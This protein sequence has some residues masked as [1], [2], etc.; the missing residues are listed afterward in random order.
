M[1]PPIRAATVGLGEATSSALRRA[2]EQDIEVFQPLLSELRLHP[3]GTPILNFP[4]AGSIEKD[5]WLTLTRILD[6]RRSYSITAKKYM[7]LGPETCR[8]GD[9][10]WVLMGSSVPFILRPMALKGVE[11]ETVQVH[12]L[13]GYCFVHGIMDGEVVRDSLC[14]VEMVGLI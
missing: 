11:D 12:R 4:E 14:D 9:E 1:V 8:E 6:E 13:Q 5:L 2:R 3:P 10:V 7:G